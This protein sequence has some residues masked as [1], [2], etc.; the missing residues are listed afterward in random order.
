MSSCGHII[1][2][3]GVI[4]ALLTPSAC[5]VGGDGMMLSLQGDLVSE[6]VLTN[7]D[8]ITS[9]DGLLWKDGQ[10]FIADEGGAA[11][12]SWK[13]G[14]KIRTLADRRTGLSSPEDLAI[15]SLGR[16]YAS[17]DNVG[18][19]WRIEPGR[20]AVPVIDRRGA[21][22]TEGL[23]VRPDGALIVGT[24]D[25]RL[26]LARGPSRIEV[27]ARMRKPESLAWDDRGDLYVADNVADALY[28]ITRAGG[29]QRL[30]HDLPGFSPESIH[31]SRGVLFITDSKNGKLFQYTERLGLQPLA[32]FG[33]TLQNVQGITSDEQGRL[34]VSIQSD[35][36]GGKGLILRLTRARQ[37]AMAGKRD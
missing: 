19:I 9:P 3:V 16:I 33:G 28:V 34:Y 35:L 27:A 13:P 21:P 20:G 26:L 7:K 31:Y 32:V 11:V 1:K 18:G 36:H 30:I 5:H 14:G 17:D 12:R 22:S 23:A 24:N 10:L 6:V 25:H 29:M 4:L 37:T 15:D 8:G 2:R